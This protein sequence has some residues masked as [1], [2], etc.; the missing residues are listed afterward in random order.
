MTVAG[1]LAAR[2]GRWVLVALSGAGSRNTS[3]APFLPREGEKFWRAWSVSVAVPWVNAI[4]SHMRVS[5]HM[6]CV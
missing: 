5:N 4:F 6:F 3:P 2:E 1:V